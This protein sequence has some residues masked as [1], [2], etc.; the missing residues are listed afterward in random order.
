MSQQQSEALELAATWEYQG[1]QALN[2]G[3]T[4]KYRLAV[5]NHRVA[6]TMAVATRERWTT[7]KTRSVC[8]YIGK[9]VDTMAI[10]ELT[11]VSD[12][13]VLDLITHASE[14]FDAFAQRRAA[15]S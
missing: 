1:A 14:G 7:W 12:E 4:V 9:V 15:R 6:Q 2:R 3:D 10:V 13:D 5:V 8:K 11:A